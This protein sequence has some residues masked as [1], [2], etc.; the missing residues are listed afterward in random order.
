[1]GEETVGQTSELDIKA[2]LEKQRAKRWKPKDAKMDMT[3]MID[4]VF[5]LIIFFM[6]VTEITRVQVKPV[7]LPLA[8]E[9]KQDKPPP[10]NRIIISVRASHGAGNGDIFVSLKEYS[11]GRLVTMLKNAAL[12]A[13]NDATGLPKLKV[14]VRGDS[15]VEWKYVQYV[16]MACSKAM[17][18][19]VSFGTKPDSNLQH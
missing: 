12:S 14:K 18:W 1:M 16:L 13:G 3:P 17:I 9:A 5:L 15:N 11:L 7:D 2:Y 10:P 19:Q 6:I 8:I 4:V